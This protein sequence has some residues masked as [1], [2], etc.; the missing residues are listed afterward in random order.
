MEERLGDGVQGMRPPRIRT[1]VE[2]VTHR[3]NVAVV[4]KQVVMEKAIGA[5]ATEIGDGGN[6]GCYGIQMQQFDAN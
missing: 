6:E 4:L 1:Q 5:M 2:G 3:A